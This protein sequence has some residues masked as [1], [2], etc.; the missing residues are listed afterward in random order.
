MVVSKIL[1]GLEAD[2]YSDFIINAIHFFNAFY[3]LG[4]NLI[5]T[6]T[7]H[8]DGSLVGLL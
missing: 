1:W 7:T 4:V 6:L 3:E 2:F 5:S 8:D